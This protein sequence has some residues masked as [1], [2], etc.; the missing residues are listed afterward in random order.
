VIPEGWDGFTMTREFR[1]C[2]F[3]I[4]VHNPE[5]VSKGIKRMTVNGE[6]ITGLEIPS[7]KFKKTNEIDVWLG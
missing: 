7:T 4:S 2:R 6:T 1:S 5:H 3:N